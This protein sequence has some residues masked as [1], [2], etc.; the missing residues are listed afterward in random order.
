MAKKRQQTNKGQYR[1]KRGDTLIRNVE[2]TYGVDF[3]VRSDMK[4][5]TYRCK[6]RLPSLAKAL[7][8][9]ESKRRYGTKKGK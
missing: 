7:E 8:K 2:N 4:L 9:A 6:E 3:G 5:S 1:K